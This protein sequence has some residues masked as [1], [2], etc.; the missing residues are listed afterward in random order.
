VARTATANTDGAP[1]PRLANATRA[2]P[3]HM[4]EPSTN[5]TAGRHR[6]DPAKHG[7]H[8][9]NGSPAPRS[10]TVTPPTT[11]SLRARHHRRM[12]RTRPEPGGRQTWS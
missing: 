12:P 9:P 10:P 6:P 7:A 3:P 2:C 8:Q 1:D 11:H 5:V 4:L